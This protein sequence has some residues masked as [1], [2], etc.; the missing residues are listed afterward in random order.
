MLKRGRLGD[1]AVSN[2][3]STVCRPALVHFDNRTH[4]STT[5]LRAKAYKRRRLDT[6]YPPE[7]RIS[8]GL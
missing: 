2:H 7:R 1:E 3:I 4:T 8:A 6:R 5:S